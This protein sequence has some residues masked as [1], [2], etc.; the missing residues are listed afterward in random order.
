MK[1]LR[2]LACTATL[3]TGHAAAAAGFHDHLGLQLWSLRDQTKVSTT[4]ALDLA[5]GFG[6]TE[7][8]TAGTGNL[9]VADFARELSARH[10]MA[11]AAHTG[12]EALQNDLPKAIA[13]AKALG[14][15]TII[16]PWIPHD[17]E[18]GLSVADAHRVAADFNAWGEACRAAGL[19]FGWHPHGF[20]FVA[21]AHGDTPF[22]VIARETKPDLV[23]FELD[24]FWVFHAGQDPVKL[25]QQYPGRWRFLHVK[26]IRKGAV[27]GLS[28]GS[29]PPTDKVAVGDGQIDWPAVFDAA[30]KAGVTHSFIEDEGVQPLKD[31]PASLRYLK[32]LKP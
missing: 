28:T 11:V 6:F 20:E 19:Q 17:R 30:A 8:E 26:D 22:A 9:S 7:V 23:C 3:L 15:K 31:I 32:T 2:S 29:A 25:L 13:D 4:G 10:L 21:D 12:Y 27:T 16:C 18:K 1:F 24:V 5:V 14:A